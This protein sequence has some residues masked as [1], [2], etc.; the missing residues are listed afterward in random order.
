MTEPAQR[1]YKYPEC[2]TVIRTKFSSDGGKKRITNPMYRNV[3]SYNHAQSIGEVLRAAQ[4]FW[5]GELWQDMQLMSRVLYRNKNQHKGGVYFRRLG[6]LRRVLRVLDGQRVD[7]LMDQLCQSFFAQGVVRAARRVNVWQ[8]LPCAPFVRAVCER[9]SQL[10]ALVIKAQRVAWNTYVQFA[11]QTAQTLFMPLA[12]VVQGVAARVFV[13]LRGWH[14]DVCTIYDVLV[15]W[16]PY[17]PQCVDGTGTNNLVPVESLRV[18]LPFESEGVVERL[19]KDA[20]NLS[21]SQDVIG[22]R[23]CNESDVNMDSCKRFRPADYD[24]DEDLGGKPTFKLVC[25]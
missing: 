22:K 19:V 18:S 14:R 5:R 16:L 8:Q 24:N 9:I 6:E 12:L 13:V 1:E 2:H 11:G 15:R 21:V 7:E 3:G 23:Q 17:L 20:A 25:M 4:T 10:V